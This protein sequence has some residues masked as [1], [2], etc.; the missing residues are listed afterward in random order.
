M[1]IQQVEK[2][3]SIALKCLEPESKKRPTSLDI[4][5]GLDALEPESWSPEN[6]PSDPEKVRSLNALICTSPHLIL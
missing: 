3:I 6:S 2:C 5:Q 1:H 4:V